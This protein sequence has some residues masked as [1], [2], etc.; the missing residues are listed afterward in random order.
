MGGSLENWFTK[1]WTKITG[2][3][4]GEAMVASSHFHSMAFWSCLFPLLSLLLD[5]KWLAWGA[6]PWCIT[7]VVAEAGP[8]GRW[9]DVVTRT[10][11]CCPGI[12]FG[13]LTLI[14]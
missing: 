6:F 5:A 7:V 10:L 3:G 4:V 12:V 14:K 13:I 8:K 11:G 9:V 2:L 1:I